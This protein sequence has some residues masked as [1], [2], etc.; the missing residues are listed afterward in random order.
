M[1][2]E[3]AFSPGTLNQLHLKNRFIKTA[4]YEGMTPGGKVTKKLID[5]HSRIASGGVAMTTVAY[6]AVNQQGRTHENQLLLSEDQATE[7]E[8]LCNQIHEKGGLASVQITHCG[9][10]SNNR[11]INRAVSASK[12]VN[13]YGLLSGL[14]LSRAMTDHELAETREAFGKAAR[15]CKKVGFDAIELHLGHGYLLSQFLSPL[16][17]K[18]N[19][20]YG[21]DFDGRIRYPKEVIDYVRE[22][23]GE[24]FPVL[25]K[26]NLDDGLKGGW[27]LQDCIRFLNEISVNAAVLSGGITSKNAFYLLRGEVPRKKMA[28]VQETT[29]AKWGMRLFGRTLMKEYPFQ[30]NFFHEQASKV[31]SMT[32]TPLVYLGGI[33]SAAG[34]EKAMDAGF[35]YLAVGR[36]LI[37]DPDFVQKL[38]EMQYVSPCNHC[39]ECLVEMDKG[40][41]RCVL[42]T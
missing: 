30:E 25:I 21:G 28:A 27:N 41:V 19:D 26:L 31:R 5:F 34:V 12:T 9:F 8:R 36:A 42:S 20:G 37:H 24:D 23:V 35:D 14:G 3:K 4:T 38:S 18:R 22:C 32:R 17:N 10:F 11:L 40:G 7:F 1:G 29:S 15:L 16:Y 13:L 39:N 6:G 2:L 33:V